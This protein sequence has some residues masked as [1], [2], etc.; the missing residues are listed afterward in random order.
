[1]NEST[2]MVYKYNVQQLL[3][4][5]LWPVEPKLKKNLKYYCTHIHHNNSIGTREYLHAWAYQVIHPFSV[6][7][8]NNI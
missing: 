2:D 4:W 1:M 7:T 3:Q 5:L 6:H 8:F